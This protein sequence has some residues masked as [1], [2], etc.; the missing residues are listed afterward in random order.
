MGM[1]I[2]PMNIKYVFIIIMTLYKCMFDLVGVYRHEPINFVLVLIIIE[3]NS[4]W[5]SRCNTVF[6]C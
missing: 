5:C 3:I 4:A 2:H 1:Y 6:K